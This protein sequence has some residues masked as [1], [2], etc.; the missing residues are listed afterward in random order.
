MNGCNNKKLFEQINFTE[1]LFGGKIGRIYFK[2]GYGASI[3]SGEKF[4]TDSEHPYEL[5]VLKN[6]KICYNTGITCDVLGH[7]T[8]NDVETYLNLIQ[9]LNNSWG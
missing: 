8:E 7:L 6:G 5:A 3:I 9:Q 2:N 1:H 4:Y